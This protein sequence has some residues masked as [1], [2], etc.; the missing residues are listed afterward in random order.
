MLQSYYKEGENI[1]CMATKDRQFRNISWNMGSDS[2]LTSSDFNPGHIHITSATYMEILQKQTCAG[3]MEAVK[4]NKCLGIW[5]RISF[6]IQ[7]IIHVW[8]YL[9]FQMQ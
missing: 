1:I 5:H 3:L 2:V 6:F 9:Y 4:D 7:I 8:Q